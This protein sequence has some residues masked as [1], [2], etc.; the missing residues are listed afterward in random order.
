[1]KNTDVLITEIIDHLNLLGT[2]GLFT[3]V[4][5]YETKNLPI[6]LKN[7][8]IVLSTKEN[9]VTLF[10]DDNYE[11]CQRNKVV[12]RLN[13][14]TP[15]NTTL[16]N[17]Y[18]FVETILDYINDEFSN[19][20][21]AFSIEEAIYDSSTCAYKVMALMQFE[22]ETCTGA[23]TS[24]SELAAAQDFLCKTHVKDTDLHIDH[25][26]RVYLDS[27]IVCGTYMGTGSSDE[28]TVDVGFY[29]SAVIVFRDDYH[30][31]VAD[32]SKNTDL[33]LFGFAGKNVHSRGIRL[34]STGFAVKELTNFFSANSNTYL[35]SDGQVYG[36]I[37]FR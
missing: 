19:N 28:R 30:P 20:M 24:N 2:Q 8:Y 4:K 5:A 10:E 23:G 11:Y 34:V 21:T 27:P 13:C 22:Y 12:I 31:T 15:V 3:A 7:N 35:N 1:M 29:P 33:N 16:Q 36:Y 17:V 37:A 9:T 26:D 18:T 14:Y 25:K 32:L 6:P